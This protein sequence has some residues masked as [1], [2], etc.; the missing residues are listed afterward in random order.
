MCCGK[1]NVTR[2]YNMNWMWQLKF[3]VFARRQKA[4]EP[5]S[6]IEARSYKHGSDNQKTGLTWSST[7]FWTTVWICID[8]KHTRRTMVNGK[9]RGTLDSTQLNIVHANQPFGLLVPFVHCTGARCRLGQIYGAFQVSSGHRLRWTWSRIWL[10]SAEVVKVALLPPLQDLLE[11]KLLLRSHTLSEFHKF[12][13]RRRG[14]SRLLRGALL[15]IHSA[16]LQQYS[17]YHPL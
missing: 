1:E 4:P 2:C 10:L 16:L 6:E 3:K 7:H 8:V 9:S 14:Y 13:L 15:E 17:S 12:L 5:F 11:S